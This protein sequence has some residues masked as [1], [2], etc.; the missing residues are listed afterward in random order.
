MEVRGA[1][2]TGEV[3]LVQAPG[4]GRETEPA[5]TVTLVRARTSWRGTGTG[6]VTP[7]GSDSGTR[8]GYNFVGPHLQRQGLR[9]HRLAHRLW[10]LC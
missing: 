10:I 6:S 1:G 3:I 9:K 8:I 7:V 4:T 5:F 2:P